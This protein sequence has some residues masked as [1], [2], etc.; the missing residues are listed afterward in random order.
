[1]IPRHTPYLRNPIGLNRGRVG[2][3]FETDE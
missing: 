3:C 1:L 2:E